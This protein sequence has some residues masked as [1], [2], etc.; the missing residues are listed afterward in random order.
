MRV[1]AL[2][3]TSISSMLLLILLFLPR[4]L[5]VCKTCGGEA[6][7][8]ADPSACPWVKHISS[9][10]AAVGAA[11]GGAL[12]LSKLLS[13]K[14]SQCEFLIEPLYVPWR[15]SRQTRRELAEHSREPGASFLRRSFDEA[16]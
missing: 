11:V 7:D 5:S 8:G 9:N 1:V 6:C 13:P 16:G 3:S 12:T 15:P 14:L 2:S 4:V 10:A